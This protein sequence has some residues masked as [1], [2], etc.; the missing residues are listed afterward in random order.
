MKKLI[1]TIT[2]LTMVMTFGCNTTTTPAPSAGNVTQVTEEST[3]SGLKANLFGA[4]SVAII[5]PTVLTMTTSPR[6]EEFE[7]RIEL[8]E[9]KK[10]CD[11][12][13]ALE[14]KDPLVSCE[15]PSP[16][17]YC[18]E[19]KNVNDKIATGKVK[20]RIKEI[21]AGDLIAKD[22]DGN[23]IKVLPGLPSW[24]KV[25]NVTTSKN[26][27]LVEFDK[28]MKLVF[29]SGT[30][31]YCHMVYYKMNTKSANMTPYCYSYEYRTR[32]SLSTYKENLFKTA[33]GS[34]PAYS[35]TI[36]DAAAGTFDFGLTKLSDA[37][38]G[39]YL[40]R[41]PTGTLV[42]RTVTNNAIFEAY[43]SF[44]RSTSYT[45]I[46][47]GE[48]DAIYPMEILG[49]SSQG[50]YSGNTFY[51]F[52]STLTSKYKVLTN[53]P[54]NIGPQAIGSNKKK[55]AEA[56]NKL[57]L[58]F[59]N[60]RGIRIFWPTTQQQSGTTL[61]VPLNYL[62]LDTLVEGIKTFTVPNT[63]TSNPN[64]C[65]VMFLAA[66]GDFVF[67][68]VPNNNLGTYLVYAIDLSKDNPIATTAA[69]EVYGS[70]TMD[71]SS[72]NIFK[73][74]AITDFVYIAS[75]LL[76]FKA[77]GTVSKIDAAS[78][79]FTPQKMD[80]SE[81][82][83]TFSGMQGLTAVKYSINPNTYQIEQAMKSSFNTGLV[84]QDIEV[85]KLIPLN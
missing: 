34:K 14:L 57:I 4:T 37:D 6:V 72:L 78:L 52:D 5:S 84:V 81:D 11:G 83:V 70:Q 76:L 16:L 32:P 75:G 63:C 77:D 74:Y 12:Y 44:D 28:P 20:C 58:S 55:L 31:Q 22:K 50:I 51:S 68:G 21:K 42:L 66:L 80:V 46:I 59:D 29:D 47:V 71:V 10:Y 60:A 7:A 26:I 85:Q 79:G 36:L 23:A 25:V 2:F 8:T 61:E 27:M 64:S 35:E 19:I 33:D 56:N 15:N 18:E 48:T 40:D 39:L 38:N 53:A 45:R 24:N 30:I 67:V 43:K 49:T 62:D 13:T 9:D 73:T 82:T 1:K 17:N 41:G 65:V 54:I 69:I 3:A